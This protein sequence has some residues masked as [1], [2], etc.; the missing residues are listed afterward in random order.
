M[1]YVLNIRLFNKLYGCSYI[2]KIVRYVNV[3]PKVP[4]IEAV[5][6]FVFE[7]VCLFVVV[8]KLQVAI[9]ARLSRDISQ[10]V[11]ID[12]HSFISRVRISVQPSKF[13]IGESTQTLSR[14]PSRRT[15]L[16]LNEPATRRN[17]DNFNG[18][19]CSHG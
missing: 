5:H 1:M 2:D 18:N 12:C 11:R 9:L 3:V 13:F 16:Q 14:K 19:N 8:R 6:I 17:G 15:S 10:T 7:S 4:M